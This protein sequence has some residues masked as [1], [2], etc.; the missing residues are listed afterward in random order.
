MK[1]LQINSVYSFGSTGRIVRQI[2]NSLISLGHESKVIYGRN[3]AFFSD[4]IATES[5]DIVYVGNRLSQLVHLG[6]G[7][8]FDKHGLYSKLTTEKIVN[9]IEKFDP[10]IIHLHN[11]HGYYLNYNVLFSY[12]KKA[13]KKIVWTLHDCWPYTGYCAYYDYNEC[14]GWK[15]GC[16]KC[17]YRNGYP[18]RILSNSK[19]NY[20]NKQVFNMPE[21]ITIVTPS[22]W[23]ANE[24]SQ[25]FLA[26]IPIKVIHNS[27]DLSKFK[28]RESNLRNEYKLADKK[29]V[30]GVSN[31]W[32]KQ[33][34]Y[35]E[36]IKLSKILNDQY[37]IALIG[38]T[39]KQSK[40]LPNN[41][42]G[43]CRTNSIEELCEWYSI[44]EVFVNLTLEDNYPT[45]NLEAMACGT[46][47]ITYKTGGS[48]EMVENYGYIV[49]R[50]DLKKIK[51]IV[52]QTRFE[53]I[54]STGNTDNSCMEAE[55]IDLYDEI[56]RGK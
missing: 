19:N 8:F 52:E 15:T 29:V 16:R 37:V 28:F 24:V 36:Y 46:P 26:D 56:L 33:K 51:E 25:S 49:E 4:A 45:V 38:C 50:Y 42:L 39:E 48:T 6:L 23:L 34:G 27:V 11:I 47:I 2:H 55:Y 43:V 35:D 7:V 30:L 17:Q 54:I 14:D 13:N 32:T 22:K 31:K 3:G 18:Y 41:M 44:A 10:D 1:V 21:L 20:I 40:N 12:L 5:N 9:E 53:R